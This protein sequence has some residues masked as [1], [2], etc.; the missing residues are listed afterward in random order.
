MNF[1]EK[2]KINP[3]FRT[4]RYYPESF[5]F[6]RLNKQRE[7]ERIKRENG[8]VDERFLR[9]KEL[10]NAYEGKRC[11]IVATGP[12]LLTSDLEMIKDELSFGMNSIIYLFNDT[13]WRPT[14]YG[15]QD[16]FVFDKMR[17]AIFE[18]YPKKSNVFIGDNLVTDEDVASKEYIVFPFN[19][20]YHAFEVNYRKYFCNFSDDAYGMVYDGYSIT[21]SLI[22]IAVYMGFKE[23]YLLGCDCSYKKGA[24]NHVV[25]SG[26]VDKYDYLN[27]KRMI[28]AYEKA[29][30][31]ADK[32]GISIYNTT[33]GGELE[34]FKRVKL[35]DVL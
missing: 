29:K 22:E 7:E 18:N 26:H 17:N 10:K 25:E 3:I 2:I 24:K 23:I 4:I 32:N 13:K 35:E 19:S 33:R 1:F 21:Y 34:V 15:I 8:F 27:Y 6:K 9:I 30:E 28:I 11:F 14:F 20:D 12:S 31:Y 16:V 5:K